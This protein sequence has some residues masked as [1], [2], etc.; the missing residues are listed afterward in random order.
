MQVLHAALAH[1]IIFFAI[2][3]LSKGTWSPL[4]TITAAD[5]SPAELTYHAQ[6]QRVGSKLKGKAVILSGRDAQQ[7]CSY[8]T[9]NFQPWTTSHDSLS[10]VTLVQA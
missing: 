10:Q 4:P 2:Y 7:V 3:V 1:T 6:L 9:A 5:G 8:I